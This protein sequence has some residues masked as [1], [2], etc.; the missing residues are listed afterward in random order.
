MTSGSY[1][2]RRAASSS[3]ASVVGVCAVALL[4]F[5]P[6]PEAQGNSALE[7]NGTSQFGAAPVIPHVENL[8]MD[9]WANWSGP[10][11]SGGQT[12][13]Y[14]GHSGCTGWGIFVADSGHLGVLVGG[15]DFAMSAAQLAA[16]AWHQVRAARV[17]QTFSI[18]LDGVE[19]PLSANPTP[20]PI[21]GCFNPAVHEAL[22]VGVGSGV[23][24]SPGSSPGDAY[25]GVVDS[26]RVNGIGKPPKAGLAFWK[27][28]EGNGSIASDIHGL[29]LTLHNG[30]FWVAGH[31]R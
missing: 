10:T 25:N 15:I 2:S 17:D 29:T 30:P 3:V 12:I 27:L 28:D 1:L 14:N 8:W 13:M 19:Y 9:L 6:A 4:V 24:D 5:A 21:A 26:V 22:I 11:G 16:G 31:G 23:F 7:F 18:E 20:R